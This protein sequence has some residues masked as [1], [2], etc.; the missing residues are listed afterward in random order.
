MSETKSEQIDNLVQQINPLNMEKLMLQTKVTLAKEKYFETY[1]E[2]NREE[3]EKDLKTLEEIE[4]H[5]LPLQSQ[6]R[7]LQTKYLVQYQGK[8]NN[9]KN[10]TVYWETYVEELLLKTDLD[11]DTFINGWDKY[12]PNTDAKTLVYEVND[13]LCHHRFTNFNILNIKK[14]E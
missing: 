10:E 12:W 1:N 14:I 3:I 8:L 7:N 2:S 6:L 5:L 9:P 13:F 4:V 11:I